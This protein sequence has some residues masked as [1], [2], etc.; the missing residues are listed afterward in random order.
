M[1]MVLWL[2]VGYWWSCKLASVRSRWRLA[3]WAPTSTSVPL[4]R[5]VVPFKPLVCTAGRTAFIFHAL[6]C[7]S[8]LA[9]AQ[10]LVAQEPLHAFFGRK[11]QGLSEERALRELGS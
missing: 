7:A 11:S 8:P 4:V 1:A 9:G 3:F 5:S 2:Y 6:S 10:L